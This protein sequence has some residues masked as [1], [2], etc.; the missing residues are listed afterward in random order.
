MTT[1]F[2]TLYVNHHYIIQT[3]SAPL[4]KAHQK[5]SRNLFADHA[6]GHHCSLGCDIRSKARSSNYQTAQIIPV[7]L[8]HTRSIHEQVAIAPYHASPRVWVKV[9]LHHWHLVTVV[10]ALEGEWPWSGMTLQRV[11]PSIWVVGVSLVVLHGQNHISTV[12][13]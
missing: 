5:K 11:M 4:R 9:D 12:W 6:H 8:T 1:Q 2:D 10:Q 3:V 7:F 13:S